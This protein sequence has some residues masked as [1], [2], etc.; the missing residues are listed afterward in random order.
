MTLDTSTGISALPIDANAY[1]AAIVTSSHEAIIGTT[2]D[3]TIVS[4]NPGAER[5]YR[6]SAAEAVGQSISM[7]IPPGREDEL[8]VLMARL[9]RGEAIAPFE[10]RRRTKDGR[11]LDI[12]LVI[13]PVRHEAGHIVGA[14]AFARDITERSRLREELQA[15]VRQQAAV[16]DLGQRAL[17]CTFDQ[18]LDTAV[19]RLVETLDVEY[20]KVLELLPDGTALR[21][22]AGVGWH[23]G[24][25]GQA[26][27]GAGTDSQAGYTLRT[28]GPVIV[29]DLR[30]ETR[31]H[32][33]PLLRQHGVVSGMSTIIRGDTRPF[34]VLGI[35]TTAQRTFTQDDIHFLQAVANVIA[36]ALARAEAEHM[37]EDRVVAR[38][39]ELQVLLNL[40]HDV[41]ATLERGPLAQLILERV[42]GVVDYT[43]AAI[44]ILDENGKGLHLLNYFGPIPQHMLTWYWA[45]ASHEYTRAV[46]ERGTPVIIDD[47]FAD[48]PLAHAF[49][50]SRTRDTG[51]LRTDVRTW[52]GV[53]MIIGDR[54]TGMLSVET[55][56]VGAYTDHHAHLFQA[57]ASHAAVAVENARLYEQ[58]RGMAALEERQ[59]LARELHDSVSQALFGIALGART[60]RTLIDRDPKSVVDPLEYILS[61]AET[62]LAEMRALTFELRPDALQT[63]GLVPLLEKQVEVLRTR[64]KMLVTTDLRTEPDVSVPVKEMLYRIAQEAMHNSVKHARARKID[65]CL[66]QESGNVV[67][68]IED[69]GVG[70][71]V[72]GSYPGHLGLRSMRERADQ[73]GAELQVESTLG[74]GTRIRV[75]VPQRVRAS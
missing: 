26:T 17:E 69:D 66:Q 11:I 43:G 42:H 20:A 10:T 32:G 63:E 24:L 25:V 71:D 46:I 27:V 13:S 72:T 38:T 57:V 18:L 33:P 54:V 70:F 4:R 22:R 60:A 64:H 15:R 35:H 39:R 74:K 75:S 36:A 21:L 44:F 3:G 59:K 14:S 41:A 47:V 50:S 65:I 19:M 49:R 55:D 56:Q 62:G 61:L 12:T 30:T 34:G 31:F 51:E 9:Q 40:S 45:V 7:L 8:P 5:L 28:N 67:L 37:L 29:S 68:D 16:A 48:T 58:A 73:H 52:M 1:L 2:L 53:P 6:Y 23:P